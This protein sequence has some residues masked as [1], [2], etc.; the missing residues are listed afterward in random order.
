MPAA[1]AAESTCTARHEPTS[2]IS[3]EHTSELQSPVHP[4]C[5]H[6]LEKKNEQQ[7]LHSEVSAVVKP[8]QNTHSNTLVQPKPCA[9]SVEFNVYLAHETAL[10]IMV[11]AIATEDDI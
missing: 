10:I 11:C 9:T 6:L 4:V 5:R 2:C 8:T 3:E 1:S 7:K